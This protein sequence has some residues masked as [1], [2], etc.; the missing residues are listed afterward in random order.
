[1]LA[2]NIKAADF[3]REFIVGEGQNTEW[4]SADLAAHQEEGLELTTD[5]ISVRT[6]ESVRS[7]VSAKVVNRVK[8]FGKLGEKIKA[9]L[10][11]L[12]TESYDQHA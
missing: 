12:P 2:D 7:R 9:A 5:A 8:I 10:V 11:K 3:L 4:L 6:V 1:M